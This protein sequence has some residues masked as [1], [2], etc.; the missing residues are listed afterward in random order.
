MPF[1]VRYNDD[2]CCLLLHL[3]RLE[4][5]MPPSDAWD[6]RTKDVQDRLCP[7]TE[8]SHGVQVKSVWL[9]ISLSAVLFLFAATYWILRAPPAGSF[10]EN[11]FWQYSDTIRG[12]DMAVSLT[13]VCAGGLL[14]GRAVLWLRR[15]ERKRA[16]LSVVA[17]GALLLGSA[18]SFWMISFLETV[19]G[20]R[21]P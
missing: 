11:Q 9:D 19:S 15:R 18:Y 1:G 13:L 12:R 2:L 16:F 7:R 6:P 3:R 10:P 20:L 8:R 17:G 4:G 14:E 21:G 5:G